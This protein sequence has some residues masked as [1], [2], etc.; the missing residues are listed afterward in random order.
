MYPIDGSGVRLQGGDS[1]SAMAVASKCRHE[2]I[3]ITVENII[4]CESIRQLASLVKQPK[5]EA[6]DEENDCEFDLSPIQSLYFK[7]MQAQTTQFNQSM[8]LQIKRPVSEGSLRTA[9]STLVNTHSM[10]RARFIR[11]A[12]GVWK[13]YILRDI[14]GSYLFY[15]F[16]SHRPEDLSLEI[17][18]AQKQV[19]VVDGPAFVAVLFE[20]SEMAQLFICAHHLVVD[21]VSWS[22]IVQDLNDLLQEKHITRGMSYQKWCQGLKEYAKRSRSV[23]ALPLDDVP[24]ADLAYW[25]MEGLTNHHGD[26]TVE[27]VKLDLVATDRLLSATQELLQVDIV[28]VL[29]GVLLVSFTHAFP[30]RPTPA[31]YN[32]GHG[33]EPCI[34]DIDLSRTVGWFTTLSPVHLPP[35][36]M[37]KDDLDLLKSI[38][39]IHDLRRRMPEKGASYFAQRFLTWDGSQKYG[40]HWPMEI[41][42]NY[43]GQ[44]K[45]SDDANVI[46]EPVDGTGQAINAH[47]DIGSRVP[48]FALIDVSAAVIQ[49]SLVLLFSYNKSMRRQAGIQ[50]WIVD[51]HHA[52]CSIPGHAELGAF[53]VHPEVYRL[54]PL[55]FG[56]LWKI[57]D[58]LANAGIT[59]L[60]NVEAIYP[61][62]PMQQ[63][64]LLS[65][66]RDP[67]T[68]S[69][70]ATFEVRP[71][72]NH[73]SIDV[74][75]L[76]E[77][78]NVVIRRHAALRTVFVEGTHGMSLMDQVVLKETRARVLHRIASTEDDAY[79]ILST[80]ERLNFRDGQPP[81]RFIICRSETGK[82]ICRLDITNALFDG[83]S[84]PI[85]LRDLSRAYVNLPPAI[86]DIPLYKSFVAYLQSLPKEKGVAYWR[87]YLKG[88]EP[89]QFPSLAGSNSE[90]VLGSHSITLTD[91]FAKMQNYCRT[92]GITSSA[93]LQLAWGL[94]LR[95]YIGSDEICFGYITSGR[96][97]PV[98]GIE[99]AVGA[100][101]N[102]LI[103]RAILKDDILVQDALK[104]AQQDFVKS[105]EYQYVSLA[106]VQHD[107]GLSE[108]SLF[109]TV[110]TLQR[111]DLVE[112]GNLPALSFEPFY[113]DDPSEYKLGINVEMTPS[114]IEVHFTY[115][116][117]HLSQESVEFIAD[118]FSHIV[119][120]IIRTNRPD[121]RLKDI[122]S[123]GNRS[124]VSISRWNNILPEAIDR[125]VHEVIE[126]QVASQPPTAKAIEAWDGSFTYRDLSAKSSRLASFLSQQGVGPEV[127]VPLLFEKSAWIIVAQLAVLKAGGAFVSLD[128]SHPED[129]LRSLIR[130][131]NACVVLTSRK[132]QAKI[133][134]VCNSV[135]TVDE[136]L[137][138]RLPEIGLASTTPAKPSS[139]AYIIFTSGSTGK[140][141]GTIIEH[142]QLC[143]SS[144]AHGNALQMNTGT[145]TLQFASYAFDASVMEIMTT[146][147]QGG[148]VC[149]P[150]EEER[151]NDIASALKKY[152]ANWMLLTPSL[153]NTLK[154]E[155]MSGLDVLVMGGEKLTQTSIER[156]SKSVNLYAAYGPSE[157]AV[158]SCS[159]EKVAADGTVVNSEAANIGKAVGCRAWIVDPRD[160]NRLVPV[161]AIGELLIE[162]PIVGRGYLHDEKTNESFV[163][164]PH[165][166]QRE[167]FRGII[168]P[169]SP[170]YRTG[171]LVR[172]N[173]DGTITYLTRADRQVK[174]NGQRI[175]IG[176]IEFQ[177]TQHLPD[178]SQVAVD[179]VALDS[180]F[181]ARKLAMFFVLPVDSEPQLDGRLLLPMNPL[182]HATLQKL[183]KSLADILPSYML[184]QFFFP[185]ASLPVTSSGKL[186]R[187]KLHEE[188]K[189]LSEDSIKSYSLLTAIKRHAPTDK[190]QRTLQGLW[191]A[192]LSIPESAI[193]VEDSFFRLGGD[194]LAAMRLVALARSNEI[195]LSVVD[196]FQ[197]PTLKDM[198]E[199]CQSAA[200]EHELQ[201]EPFALL[202]G[203]DSLDELLNEVTSQIAVH[204]TEIA[205]IYPCSPLQEGLI[206]LSLRQRGAYV[207]QHVFKLADD[208]DLNRFQA[209]WQQLV[210]ELD[211][212]R[213]RII[214]TASTNF[215]Q[216]VLK[217]QN[218]TWHTADR[219]SDISRD[220]MRVPETEGAPLSRF[221]I[222]HDQRS[223]ARYFVWLIHHALYDA[224]GLS[225]LLKRVEDIYWNRALKS[226]VTSY[227]SFINYLQQRDVSASD[228][229]WKSY[230]EGASPV[231]FPRATNSSSDKGSEQ[232]TI[233]DTSELSQSA[234]SSLDITMPALIR[235]AWAIVLFN[236]TGSDDVCFG[237]TLIGRNVDVQG[238]T[239][240][241]GPVLTTVPTRIRVDPEMEMHEFLLEAHRK[242]TEMIP[243]QHS[244]LQHIRRLSQ[245]AALACD[246][247]NL[248]D[249]Q[250]VQDGFDDELW[251]VKEDEVIGNF[252][253]YPLVVECKVRNTNVEIIMH[254][255]ANT[256]S[257]WEGERLLKQ[258]SH[259][260]QQL[261]SASRAEPRKVGQV[262]II[263]P[264]DKEEISW[265]NRREPQLVDKCIH[266]IFHSQSLFRP[267]S[268]AVDSWDDKL[269][270]AELEAHASS[271]AVYLK[272]LGVGPEVFVPLCLDKSAWTIVAMLAVLIAGGAFVPLDP[273]HPLS[274]HLE[275]FEELRA[276]I[277]LV[278]EQHYSRYQGKVRHLVSI[279]KHMIQRLPFTSILFDQLGEATSSNAAYAIFTSGSTGKAKGITI[280]H[281]AFVSSSMAF[282]PTTRI[283]S[284]CRVLQFA[285]LSFDAAVME[286]LS[287]LTLGG[288]VCVPSEDERLTNLAE[289]IQRMN[290]S[291]A[292]LTPSV[293]NLLDASTVPCLKVL[294]CGGEAMSPETI[295]RWSGKVSL[296]NAY[297]PSEASVVATVNPDVSSQQPACI[298]YGTQPTLTWVVDPEDCNTLTPLGAVG[299]LALE[300]PTLARGYL[301]DEAK[302]R[303]AFVENPAWA[304]SFPSKSGRGRRIHLTGDLVKYNPDGSLEYVGRKDNQVKLNGQRL[305]LGEVEHRLETD[306][307]VRHVVVTM[308]KVGPFKKRLIA[309]LSINAMSSDKTVLSVNSCELVENSPK[310]NS[311]L[312]EIK[313]RLSSQLPSYM[314]PQ[315]WAV[316]NNLPMLVSGKLDRKKVKTWVEGV[317]EE[318]YQRI[319][320]VGARNQPSQ[321]DNDI[322]ADGVTAILRELWSQVLNIPVENVKLDQSFL[323][324]GKYTT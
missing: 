36:V 201:L 155:N 250:T 56:G 64:I 41:M 280:E 191:A 254:Y 189:T 143:T 260:L 125:C 158:V 306:P 93:L 100:F 91:D 186:D 60:E 49:G 185:V 106:E 128:P 233:S 265:W 218:I 122:D 144:F 72:H 294:V 272:Q 200:G 213:T 221:T 87:Q 214:H 62:T 173:P 67:Q 151:L 292:L 44:H 22:V 165:W 70:R 204:R 105:M 203:V 69:Y 174:I 261:S 282:G 211:L 278:S 226:R 50:Q 150:S 164:D 52:L 136:E 142:S 295:S 237:E 63:G 284:N 314:V 32:E 324:Q 117:D 180:Q 160:Y 287:T 95:C 312:T 43:L 195:A 45:K 222:V 168:Q 205:D 322:T 228:Q 271:L 20:H 114:V 163:H 240:I 99:Y 112:E 194:S 156:W 219:L 224:W 5:M 139:A 178:H 38:I 293:A 251:E 166:S 266:E 288:C 80:F 230:L 182:F 40:H 76:E 83:S 54:L 276:S 59:S 277:V 42:F 81:H 159:S 264:E 196:I 216:V 161:G 192:V 4:T 28:D 149:V 31:I 48:R 244:G 307:R 299:E 262:D 119:A 179:V 96:D 61:C 29:L 231:A 223:N 24:V 248:L 17:E 305:D 188:V 108:T 126:E 175:E 13:Q 285:S 268:P 311:E 27:E 145:R 291:W 75:Q 26:V 202:K 146:L 217:E 148:C 15:S 246:F 137:M 94:V 57:K 169:G 138:E 35:Q 298:G 227:A 92:V 132:Q 197:T 315:A 215:V 103:Y 101:I 207:A 270:Y 249:V 290:V 171:D 124:C 107:L 1:I 234:L 157:C 65:Q 255:D 30:D 111:R 181:G 33:R 71:P 259:I 18:M 133:S 232:K 120:S 90:R 55:S 190:M 177:C 319:I 258:F 235:A 323:S 198:A 162:G 7:C 39:W 47:F 154:P 134:K 102:M 242:S 141:K 253:T 316:V 110:F 199:A 79:S 283:D 289:A 245:S 239:E 53:R 9:L 21:M 86:P 88:T 113:A 317:Q 127:F 8:L 73:G 238:V 34:G 286:I 300:G 152:Q 241:A 243:H 3:G 6:V 170:M 123:F 98:Q 176:E 321:S 89:C 267:D 297:G 153:A 184:P 78:W 37:I 104:T 313:A 187:R 301:N 2:G 308:P 212:L 303:A 247:Q 12:N 115:W 82:V 229:F 208:V 74:N 19:N 256:I 225:I 118:T 10:L 116:T 51:C 318:V 320:G 85:I 252:F 109:D 11:D 269:T 273:N 140:P 257:T 206:T 304:T 220:R 16:S 58:A 68:Y 167:A 310:L 46:L 66:L 129:R 147:M 97:V 236:R 183:E 274:R 296:I 14:G 279:D 25:G 263:S 309:I 275:I 23:Q 193:G 209:A 172:Y 135:V 281:R 131:V 130:D 210:D 84:M 77:A 121:L 302:T